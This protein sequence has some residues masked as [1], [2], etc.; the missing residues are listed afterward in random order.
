MII[1]QNSAKNYVC[2]EVRKRLVYPTNGKAYQWVVDQIE[3]Y[4]NPSY[5]NTNYTNEVLKELDRLMY[6][7]KEKVKKEDKDAV[8]NFICNL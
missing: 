5:K 4:R 2:K 7:T 1:N 6:L 3:Y 8:L